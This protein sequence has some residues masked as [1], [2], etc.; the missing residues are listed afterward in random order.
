MTSGTACGLTV[1]SGLGKSDA[2][3]EESSESQRDLV[4]DTGTDAP[5]F[6]CKYFFDLCKRKKA[7]KP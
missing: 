2:T 6:S 7:G 1:G 3:E 5:G 4:D